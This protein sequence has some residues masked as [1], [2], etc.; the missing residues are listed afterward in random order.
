MQLHPLTDPQR[1]S[2]AASFYLSPFSWPHESHCCL[3]TDCLPW[4]SHFSALLG[5]D[6]LQK[7]EIDLLALG[8]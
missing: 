4:T 3:H 1:L 7:H 5:A 2:T 6:V 8:Y